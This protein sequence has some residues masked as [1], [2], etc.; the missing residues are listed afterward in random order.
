MHRDDI[1]AYLPTWLP[2]KPLLPLV[3]IMVN[4]EQMAVAVAWPPSYQLQPVFWI[5]VLFSL[6]DYELT[7][8]ARC[9]FDNII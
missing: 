1:S 9:I 4:S 5:K 8:T 2:A 7:I 3:V 6:R